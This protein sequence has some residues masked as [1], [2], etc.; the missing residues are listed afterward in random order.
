M[1]TRAR[2]AWEGTGP[3]ETEEEGAAVSAIADVMHKTVPSCS[4][5]NL[6]ARPQRLPRWKPIVIIFGLTASLIAAPAWVPATAGPP[7][8]A[9]WLP[10]PFEKRSEPILKPSASGLDDKN[11]YNMAVVRAKN[12]VLW[13]LY[14]GESKKEAK[15]ECTGRLFLASS[16]D[17]IEW[18]R[19]P[20][21]VL[22]GTEPYEK[23]GVEDPRLIEVD[24]TFYLTYSGYDG[25]IA[26]LC[27]ATSKDLLEW[28][29]HGPIFPDFPAGERH[30]QGWTKSGA[31][32]PQR[33]KNGKY[34][35]AFGDTDLWLAY[36]DDLLHWSYDPKP[37]MTPRKNR[38][39]SKLIEPGPPLLMTDKGILLLYN[40][41]DEK[42]RYALFGALLDR[43]NPRQVLARTETPLLEPTLGWEKKGYVPHVVFAESLILDRRHGWLLYYGGADRYI[44]VAKAQAPPGADP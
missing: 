3:V 29:K 20:N 36:S 15:N 33:L 16:S 17:G 5:L 2:A 38:R 40:S 10:G 34:V 26:R 25:K 14:R 22:S 12:S 21:P 7:P 13:M 24:D 11:V 39:D 43:D 31:I 9:D 4:G 28:K 44:G 35:M 19:Y 41:A 6:G 32:L 23:N 30:P 1:E 8:R 42:N 18:K 37:F 27:L